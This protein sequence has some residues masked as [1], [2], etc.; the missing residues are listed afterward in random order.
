MIRKK[1]WTITFY[2]NNVKNWFGKSAYDS[3]IY[4]NDIDDKVV[5]SESAHNYAE[6]IRGPR[7]LWF[8]VER[9]KIK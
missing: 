7:D 3:T 1:W 5:D 8:N 6:L 4:V 9:G 2:Q